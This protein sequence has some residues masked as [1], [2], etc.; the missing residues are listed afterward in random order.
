MYSDGQ[1][2][3]LCSLCPAWPPFRVGAACMSV[4]VPCGANCAGP[5]GG[6]PTPVKVKSVRTC[7]T[8]PNPEICYAGPC[9]P[10]CQPGKAGLH[11]RRVPRA[12]HQRLGGYLAGRTRR[13][14]VPGLRQ[15]VCL[16]A[17]LPRPVPWRLPVWP[18][19]R[20]A[21]RRSGTTK[22]LLVWGVFCKSPVTIL[23]PGCYKAVTKTPCMWL[24]VAR[25]ALC[26]V[27][28]LYGC[29]QAICIA[30]P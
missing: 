24:C 25:P 27:A 3:C 14:R 28:L 15:A 4:S 23:R 18:A 20:C 29:Y 21:C 19:P 30:I 17:G 9:C 6:V 13:W 11:A 16:H 26:V 5:N 7:Q 10:G 2:G 1:V 8:G 12:G 22:N